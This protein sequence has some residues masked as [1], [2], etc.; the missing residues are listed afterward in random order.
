MQGQLTIRL[1]S[2]LEQQLTAISQRFHKKRSEIIRQALVRFI[3]E[4]ASTTE[5]SPWHNVQHLFGSIETGISD[6]G[7][8]HRE[9]LRERF[10]RNG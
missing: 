4:E 1:D 10:K 2:T 6:L 5:P 3:T 7:E 8:A 9:H